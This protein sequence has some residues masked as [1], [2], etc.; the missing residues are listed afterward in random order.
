MINLEECKK[1]LQK[2]GSTYTDEQV[3]QTRQLIYKMANLDYQLFVT[4]KANEDANSNHLH[5]SVNR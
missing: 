4:Q 3:K 1:L 2:N 5:K